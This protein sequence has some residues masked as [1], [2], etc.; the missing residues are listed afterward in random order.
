MQVN[1]GM[2]WL[3]SGI[4]GGGEGFDGCFGPVVEEIEEMEESER[5][6]RWLESWRVRDGKRWYEKFVQRV[7]RELCCGTGQRF[8]GCGV[9]CFM[10]RKRYGTMLTQCRGPSL[11]QING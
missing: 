11:R 1:V 6:W 2:V 5:W 9:V 8:F 10:F 4:F 7:H 3:R